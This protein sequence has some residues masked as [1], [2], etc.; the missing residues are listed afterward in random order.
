MVAAKHAAGQVGRRLK[1]RDLHILMTAVDCG[2]MGKAAQRLA[3]S[4]PVV[5]K[6]ISDMERVLGVRLLD[7]SR[8]GIEPTAPGRALIK[9]GVAIF[10]E[11]Q[12]G[13]RDL[14][15][16][17]DPTGGEVS[18]A[19][20]PPVAGAIVGPAIERLSRQH[21]RMRFKTMVADTAPLLAELQ[22]RNVDLVISRMPHRI[23]GEFDT[24]ILFHDAVKIVTGRKNPLARRRS[25]A[26]ADLLGEPWLLSAENSYFGT[27]QAEVFRSS[28][29]EPPPTT[30]EVSAYHLRLELLAGNRFLTVVAGF[31]ILLPRPN[32]GLVALPVKLQVAPNPV[33]IVTLKSR[34]LSPT[35]QLFIECVREITKPLAKSA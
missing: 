10:D 16:L 2:T 7:R 31:S 6:A 19:V 21:P 20:T 14:E 9:R 32:P 15:A 34:S 8:S 18:V 3:V 4:Q 33:G 13:L 28:G 11:M 5:S 25:L 24:E 27:L 26:L 35:A 23:T 12:Q 17:S 22:A 30:V 29:L 1:L